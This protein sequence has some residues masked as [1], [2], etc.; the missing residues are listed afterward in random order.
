MKSKIRSFQVAAV[1]TFSLALVIAS[2]KKDNQIADTNSQDDLTPGIE[3][4]QNN[5]SAVAQ[6][7]DVFAITQGVSA[8]D[9][10]EDVSLGIANSI[11][12]IP[13]GR[14]MGSEGAR[15]YTVSVVPKIKGEWP[16]T[17]TIDFGTGCTGK[18]GK[19]R[20]GKIVS[21]FTKPAYLPGAV[22]STT[23]LDYRVDTFAISGTHKVTNTSANN[24]FS[25]KVEVINGKITNTNSGFWIKHESEREF[26]QLDG[27]IIGLNPFPHGFKITGTSRGS[28]SNDK[29]WRTEII[30]PLVKK[31]D[32]QW[33]SKGVLKIWWNGNSTP[34][35]LDFGN[36]DCDNKAL[37]TYKDHSKEIT[38]H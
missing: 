26:T 29:S 12:N 7:D 8:E 6:F 22:V 2:C 31:F 15:C 17:V 10:G 1:M 3:A 35:S 4:A 9:A 37:L 13:N 19:T 11:N 20:M 38:L 36:G 18:D 14:Q 30:N 24:K 16:K 33:I 34:A 25:F 28:N 21:I 32:C 27:S 5:T 23:F